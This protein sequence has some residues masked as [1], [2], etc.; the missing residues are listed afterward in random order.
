MKRLVVPVLA[1][2]LLPCVRASAS[3]QTAAKLRL[4]DQLLLTAALEGNA[5]EVSDALQQGANIEAR[6]SNGWTPLMLA[7][8]DSGNVD[9]VKLLLDH[10]ADIDAQNGSGATALDY[11]A[12]SGRIEVVKLLLAYH[13]NL[14]VKDSNGETALFHAFEISSGGAGIV[15]LLLANHA[16]LQVKNRFGYTPLMQAANQ[17]RADIVSLLLEY[18]PDMEAKD[19]NGWTPLMGAA[20]YGHADVVKLLLENHANLETTDARGY[21]PLMQAAYRGHADVVTLLLQY[22]ADIAAAGNGPLAVAA[23]AGKPG[24]VKLLLDDHANVDVVYNGQ[25][26]LMWAAENGQTDVVRL[27]VASHAN[28]DVKDPNGD[29]AIDKAARA[30]DCDAV[31]ALEQGSQQKTTDCLQALVT[32]YQKSP[33]DALRATAI[34][35]AAAM[36]PPPAISQ[37]ARRPFVQAVTLFKTA[38]GA[39]DLKT[40][41]DLYQQAVQQAPWFTDA[42][43]NQ[44]L[45]QEQAGDFKGA[46]ASMQVFQQLETG[47]DKDQPTLDRIYA[48]EAEAK[49]AADKAQRQADLNAAA[50]AVRDVIGGRTLYRFF[51]DSGL[52]GGA[53]SAI[54]AASGQCYVYSSDRYG[55]GSHD[56]TPMGAQADVTVEADHVVVTLGAQ[57]FCMPP[58]VATYAA[59]NPLDSWIATNEAGLTDCNTPPGDV[60]VLSFAAQPLALDGLPATVQSALP[61]T[62]SMVVEKCAN[63]ECN[64]AD[65]VI[66][67]LKP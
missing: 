2:L 21:T 23:M 7:V 57:R 13:A 20:N 26:P 1:I 38:Q 52:N 41:L 43:Y 55:F 3:A 11:A 56:G 12:A 51:V 17:G 65:I 5:T 46:L 33:T 60:R 39:A 63:P 28:R 18:H 34:R 32:Q 27:L 10:H 14:E 30:L 59:G 36:N 62:R 15:S 4:Q 37:D 29:T 19:T 42:W 35:T 22:H 66:Y 45:A 31:L 53:C 25:T 9:I 67:W 49:S 54:A 58:A 24:I 50:N 40:V 48:L 16:D 47:G 8:Y 6:D 44:S 61:G 64:P